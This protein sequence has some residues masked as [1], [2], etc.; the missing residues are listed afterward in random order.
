[1]RQTIYLAKKGIGFVNPEPLVGALL[2]KNEKIVGRGYKSLYGENAVLKAIEDAGEE[3]QDSELYTNFEPS[4]KSVI[5]SGIRKL[6]IGTLD[7]SKEKASNNLKQIFDSGIEVE[8]NVLKEECD[9]L[10]EIYLHFVSKGTP[11][12]FTKW[13]MSLDGKIA[14]KTGDSKWISSEES[15]EFVHHLRQRVAAIMVGENTVR[16][17][18]P[19]L[20]TRL[21]GVKISNPIRVILSR[22]GDISL[23]ANVLK[24]DEATKT[25]VVVSDSIAA[26]KEKMLL[27]K[28]A[29][30]IKLK[31][32][33]GKIDFKEIVKE[34]GKRNIDSLYIEGGSGVL[35]SAFESKIVNKVYV[36][37]APKIIGGKDAVTA[38]SGKGIEKMSDAI[39]LSKVA[40]EVIGNDVIIS[41][42]IND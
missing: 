15:L 39:V 21:K 42:Y 37:V 40:H 29:D 11:F 8:T 33:N 14:T 20:T 28:G 3:A 23:D 10:N 22:Q 19:M 31:E 18:N 36:A 32:F 7:I 9:K 6:Y 17:D 16:L 5:D 1:M 38:V 26:Q 41:G 2:I 4:F 12:V 24:I 30:I 13:A 25:I 35:A 34:L 27:D